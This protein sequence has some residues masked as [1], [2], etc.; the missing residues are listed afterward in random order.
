MASSRTTPR[1][2]QRTAL[3][4]CSMA[5]PTKRAAGRS[6]YYATTLGG[7]AADYAQRVADALTREYMKGGDAEERDWK[8]HPLPLAVV[9]DEAL[10]LGLHFMCLRWLGEHVQ[11]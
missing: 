1:R 8:K 4:R 3:T 11:H 9:L 6:L 2:I 10:T 5:S 7:E